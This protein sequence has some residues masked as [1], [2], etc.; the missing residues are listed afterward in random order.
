MSSAETAIIR[1]IR[2]KQVIQTVYNDKV[3]VL[4][5]HV[6]GKKGSRVNVLS[7]QIG[8]ES[9][10]PIE[11]AGSRKNW[12]CMHLDRF[13]AVRSRLDLDWQT[14]DSHTQPQTCVDHVYAEVDY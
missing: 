3:R 12:R 1:A 7:Y 14:A 4:C 2:K 9:S 8:G 13:E 11:P 5:P 10:R 6:I